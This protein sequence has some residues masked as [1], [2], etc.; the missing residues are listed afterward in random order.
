MGMPIDTE[1]RDKVVELLNRCLTCE[2]LA[3]LREVSLAEIHAALDGEP[4]VPAGLKRWVSNHAGRPTTLRHV[5]RLAGVAIDTVRKIAAAQPAG[6][7]N[8]E[9]RAECVPEY[10]CPGCHCRVVYRPC[11]ICAALGCQAVA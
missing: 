1:R 3:L 5:A 10:I 9:F 8:V 11:V 7:L 4:A 2:E 6:Q